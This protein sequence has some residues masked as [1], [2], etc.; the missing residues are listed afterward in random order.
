MMFTTYKNVLPLT[1]E[2]K[3]RYKIRAII[4]IV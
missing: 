2:A 1:G 4:R 3:Y